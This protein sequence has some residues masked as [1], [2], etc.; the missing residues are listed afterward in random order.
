VFIE[1]D[2]VAETG[3]TNL[4]AALGETRDNALVVTDDVAMVAA[5]GG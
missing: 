2:V 1:M 4:L 3:G 5:G